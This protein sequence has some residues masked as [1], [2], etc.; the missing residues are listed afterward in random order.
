[1]RMRTKGNFSTVN[2]QIYIVYIYI[3][4]LYTS[5][6]RI[7]QDDLFKDL[8]FILRIDN[9]LFLCILV[10]YTHILGVLTEQRP[11]HVM[12]QMSFAHNPTHRSQQLLSAKAHVCF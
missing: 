5:P 4:I 2:I 8:L 1:M 10:Y 6:Q 9:F 11:L 3:Y 7:E 12:I